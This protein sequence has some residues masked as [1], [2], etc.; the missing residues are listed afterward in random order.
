MDWRFSH[1]DES[2]LNLATTRDGIIKLGDLYIGPFAA[3]KKIKSGHFLVKQL[4]IGPML[5]R[6]HYGATVSYASQSMYSQ[7]GRYTRKDGVACQLYNEISALLDVTLSTVY[8][9]DSFQYAIGINQSLLDSGFCIAINF[10]I[11]N[12]WQELSVSVLYSY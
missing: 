12:N 1:G 11:V 5:F 9:F 2:Y 8:W 7:E 10:E 3:F 6:K 4:Y